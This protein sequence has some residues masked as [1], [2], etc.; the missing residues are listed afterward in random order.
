MRAALILVIELPQM[1]L[2]AILSLSS[3]TSIRSTPS[4]AGCWT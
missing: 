3:T 1:V 4:A 2:G